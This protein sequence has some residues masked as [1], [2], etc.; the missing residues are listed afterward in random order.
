M[1]KVSI[2]FCLYLQRHSADAVESA[3]FV[4]FSI[5]G[6]PFLPFGDVPDQFPGPDVLPF[7]PGLDPVA[8]CG[9][10]LFHTYKYIS[11]NQ[12][13]IFF[14]NKTNTSFGEMSGACIV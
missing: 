14:S 8:L 12:I 6:F 3:V 7:S 10:R 4:A 2:S 11:Y 9:N 5:H 1:S 13:N